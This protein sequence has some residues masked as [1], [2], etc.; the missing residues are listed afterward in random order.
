[1]LDYPAKD[2]LFHGHPL[3]ELGFHLLTSFLHFYGLGA[4]DDVEVLAVFSEKGL[5]HKLDEHWAV[6]VMPWLTKYFF[7][8]VIVFSPKEFLKHTRVHPE[9]GSELPREYCQIERP[10]VHS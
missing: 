4:V 6:A 3:S 8:G 9:F 7:L 10:A 5:K 1:M 2:A